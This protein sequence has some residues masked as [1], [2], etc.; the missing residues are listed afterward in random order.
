M[1]RVVT[2]LALGAAMVLFSGSAANA[3]H[4][5]CEHG[6]THTAHASVPHHDN[7]GTHTAHSKIPYCPPG[8]APGRR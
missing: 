8:D 2:T 3:T 6:G 5:G 4:K 7:H 1:R